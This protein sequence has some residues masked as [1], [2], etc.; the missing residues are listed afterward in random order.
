[1]PIPRDAHYV[2]GSN[3]HIVRLADDSTVTRATAENLF[4]RERG[5]RS[6]YQRKRAFQK[7][8]PNEKAM[9]EAERK[10][11]DRETAKEAEDRLR[12]DYANNSYNYRNIDKSP[13]GPLA[14][15]LE[16]I[17]RRSS[18]ADYA[19]GDSPKVV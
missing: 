15:Y 14:K 13:N 2:P 12:A 8:P 6:N 18:G 1:M 4:A 19:V 7:S 17:G 10:G 11:I 16:S 5:Y 9:R 3:R